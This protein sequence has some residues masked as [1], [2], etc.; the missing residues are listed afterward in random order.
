MKV[1]FCE[2]ESLSLRG[3]IPTAV[4]MLTKQSVVYSTLAFLMDRLLPPPRRGRNDSALFVIANES[5]DGFAS[6]QPVGSAG[7]SASGTLPSVLTDGRER[8]NKL[9]GL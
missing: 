3:R 1:G 8:T 5:S 2:Y 9:N 6:S 7:W 4:G